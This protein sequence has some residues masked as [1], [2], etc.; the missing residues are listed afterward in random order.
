MVQ[1]SCLQLHDIFFTHQFSSSIG[2]IVIICRFVEGAQ[3]LTDN[4]LLFI[5]IF[6][7]NK[8]TV[9]I[10]FFCEVG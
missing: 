6:T 1:H 7:I 10:V 3:I 5:F 4:I 9:I 2:I 8:M